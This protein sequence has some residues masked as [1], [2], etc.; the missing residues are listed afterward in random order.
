MQ[1]W[2]FAPT[3]YM[4]RLGCCNSSFLLL[5]LSICLLRDT[6]FIQ[7]LNDLHRPLH[8]LHRLSHVES[9][10]ACIKKSPLLTQISPTSCCV[11]QDSSVYS[12]LLQGLTISYV[13]VCPTS[14]RSSLGGCKSRLA[15]HDHVGKH[16]RHWTV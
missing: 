16:V 4:L 5:L 10:L 1:T 15:F 13:A 14:H 6:V 8:A 3:I 9:S 11:T 7:S 2:I 12:I